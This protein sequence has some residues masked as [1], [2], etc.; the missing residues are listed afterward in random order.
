MSSVGG[1][2]NISSQRFENGFVY[3]EFTL[4]NFRVGRRQQRATTIAALSQTEAYET[5]IAIG[6]L[7]SSSKQIQCSMY[8][9]VNE[10]SPMMDIL[11]SRS[12][13]R[14]YNT[15]STFTK[16][17]SQSARND[18]VRRRWKQQ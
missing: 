9:R 15:Y 11:L 10:S 1:M 18:Y 14:A 7:S 4:S 16:G 17:L 8:Q 2:F 12:N 6:P 13:R 5:L 3:C